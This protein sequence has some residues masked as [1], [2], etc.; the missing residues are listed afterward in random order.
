M[1]QPG[2]RTVIFLE[3]ERETW[4][5]GRGWMRTRILT[6]GDGRAP[7]LSLEGS[8]VFPMRAPEVSAHLSLGRTPLSL[9]QQSGSPITGEATWSGQLSG[10]AGAMARR[11]QR[12]TAF[13]MVVY[14][15]GHGARQSLGADIFTVGPPDVATELAPRRVGGFRGTVFELGQFH[16]LNT[17][18]AAQLRPTWTL[19]GLRAEHWF[20]QSWRLDA[21]FEPRFFLRGPWW[22]PSDRHPARSG[23]F[24][25][26]LTK[27]WGF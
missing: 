15:M 4:M 26:F 22:D 25:A 18:V 19:P 6:S 3:G 7:R 16:G 13:G 24:G 27:E 14:E 1:P 23:A 17:L 5:P 10:E 8:T 21:G 2:G 9:L 12:S 11:Q 20:G